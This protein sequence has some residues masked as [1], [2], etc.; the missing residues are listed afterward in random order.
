MTLL[1]VDSDE[2]LIERPSPD[3]TRPGARR[4]VGRARTAPRPVPADAAHGAETSPARVLLRRH[5]TTA[6]GGLAVLL[7]VLIAARSLLGVAERETSLQDARLSLLQVS[8]AV[9]PPRLAV[10]GNQVGTPVAPTEDGL[11]ATLRAKLTEYAAGL[12]EVWPT[13]TAREL[14]QEV[15]AYCA[16][17]RDVMDRIDRRDFAGARLQDRIALQPAEDRLID[18]LRVATSNLTERVENAE[19]HLRAQVLWI[20]GGAGAMVVLIMVVV[21]RWLRRSDRQW[22]ESKVLRDSEERF[23][24]LVQNSSDLTVVCDLAGE[25]TYVSPAS[26]PILGWTDRQMRGHPIA[27]FLHPDEQMDHRMRLAAWTGR[28]R[29]EPVRVRMRCGDGS[30]RLMEAYVTDLTADRSVNGMV[31]NMRDITDRSRLEAELQ[32]AQKLEAVGQLASG[33]AHEINTP[34]QFIGDNVRFLGDAVDELLADARS[35]IATDLDLDYLSVEMPQAIAQTLDGVDRVS[36]IVQAMKAFGHPG[37][38]AKTATDINQAVRTTLVVANN[39]VGPV[40]DVVLDLAEL[41]PVWCHRGDVNQALLNLVINA[42]HA[43]A[44]KN[45]H[46]PGRGTLTVRTSVVGDAVHIDVA[47]T[48]TGVSDEIAGRLFEPFFTTKE[49]GHGTGQGLA[50][51]YALVTDRHG[52]SLTFKNN[53]LAGATFTIRIPI[54]APQ[55]DDAISITGP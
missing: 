36:T 35:R 21:T 37:T 51:A 53:E 54:N 49:V 43:M 48:G 27:E 4:A 14:R 16:I 50:L 31:A 42:V 13:T 7:I 55:T 44:E 28:E 9:M 12:T 26:W 2:R 1:E 19:A 8:E 17:I 22:T 25:L 15:V 32:H 47:D 39:V 46:G 11:S 33:I 5:G 38:E 3:L 23:R 18:A 41:P 29:N 52:G 34:I 30:Y 10:E 20:V 6:V 45:G 24:A 40:A